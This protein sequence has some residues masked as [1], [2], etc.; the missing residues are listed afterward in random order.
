MPVPH[1]KQQC[2]PK[3]VVAIGGCLLGQAVR[4]NGE[5]K[6]RNPHIDQ[7]NHC[8]RFLPLCPE[9]GIGLG[10]PRKPIRLL[11]REGK[12][13]VVDSDTQQIDY[14]RALAE[15]TEQ[16]LK[17]H[18]AI[19][20][21]VLVKGSPSCGMERVKAYNTN[22]QV[23][24]HDGI[25]I[26]ATTISALNP[27]LPMEED[28]RLHDAG[29]RE[30]FVSRIFLYS[31]W[32]RLLHSGITV[33]KLLRFYA[34]YKYKIMAH[35][36]PS[37]QQLGLLLAQPQKQSLAQLADRVIQIM[38]QALKVAA[39]RSGHVNALQH[40]QGYLKNHLS[41]ADKH[42]LTR[43]IERYR[44]GSVPLIVP[45]TLLHH[46]FN[47]FPNAYIEQQVFMSPYPE[48]LALRSYI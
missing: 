22:G 7:L 30:S 10:V 19:C 11:E 29:L 27:L 13:H 17:R 21:Y 46:H 12:V 28:G 40:I 39:T 20:G 5:S 35:H 6:R 14:T 41:S 48:E 45:M 42:E 43:V 2:H 47:H 25:G 15:F 33:D 3:P 23:T 38:M 44:D 9:V 36:V 37:Y 34:S 18:P 1:H 24:R 26:V 31:D 16:Q 32:R 4:F 8:L